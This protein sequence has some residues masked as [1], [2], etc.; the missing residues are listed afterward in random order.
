[1]HSL[2][3]PVAKGWLSGGLR[4]AVQA[5]TPTVAEELPGPA[6]DGGGAE[7]KQS[8]PQSAQQF[9]KDDDAGIVGTRQCQQPLARKAVPFTP[10][11]PCAVPSGSPEQLC[12]DGCDCA[13]CAT[14]GGPPCGV[15]SDDAVTVVSTTTTA[16]VAGVSESSSPA[17]VVADGEQLPSDT[18]EGWSAAQAGGDADVVDVVE[19]STPAPAS[20]PASPHGSPAALADDAVGECSNCVELDAVWCKSCVLVLQWLRCIRSVIAARPVRAARRVRGQRRDQQ[21]S[22]R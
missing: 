10:V 6:A 22:L 18:G 7:E 19:M 2:L 3:I 5:E 8:T 20:P 15:P 1:M 9:P 14:E 21:R 4:F 16:E 11:N 13:V 12:E 17:T